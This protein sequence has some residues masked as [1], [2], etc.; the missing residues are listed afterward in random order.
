MERSGNGERESKVKQSWI[1]N[2]REKRREKG[3]V[4]MVVVMKK[5]G[6]RFE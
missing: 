4:K 6:I 3:K 2:G 5:E 1:R